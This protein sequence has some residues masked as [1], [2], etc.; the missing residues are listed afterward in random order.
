MTERE[1]RD[2]HR[3][4]RSSSI[5]IACLEIGQLFSG[6]SEIQPQPVDIFLRFYRYILY[7]RRA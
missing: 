4:P 6:P 5:D 3:F 7:F 2:R 1:D